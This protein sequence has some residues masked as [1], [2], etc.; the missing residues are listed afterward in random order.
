[1]K[2]LVLKE[3]YKIEVRELPMPEIKED[4]ILVRNEYCAVC[5]ATDTKMYTGKHALITYPSVFGHEGAGRVVAI[6][7]KVQDIAVGDLVLGAG[8]PSSEYL[9]SFWGQYSEYGVCKG[10]EAVKIPKNISL[11]EAAIS[12]ML[13]E[14][15]N[16]CEIATIK[17]Q[18]T[19]AVIG[20]GAVGLSIITILK[21]K[22]AKSIIA[23]DV[24]PDKL[25]KAKELG[26]DVT[27]CT[28]GENIK[29]SLKEKT[30]RQE[31]DIVFEAVGSPVTYNLAYEILKYKGVIVPFGM[32]EGTMELPFRI[33]YSKELQIRWVRSTG[34]YGREYRQIILN[35]MA[36][37]LLDAKK[38]ITA[39]YPMEEFE[40]AI[41][42]IMEGKQIRV[43]IRI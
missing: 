36:K 43:I 4:E 18:D 33:L 21:H 31:V 14:A 1:M 23:L 26:A 41:K 17:A 12:H 38:L 7:S 22:F 30:G 10:T 42:T 24:N 34:Q 8:Y 19:I 2:A 39:E 11:K 5:N 6:G 9:G 35:M 29:E 13:S 25:K 28:V 20:C 40:Q 37:G 27:I 16:A 15:L 3:K 32:I